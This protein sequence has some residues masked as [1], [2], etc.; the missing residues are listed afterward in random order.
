[1]SERERQEGQRERV[2][3]RERVPQGLLA[4]ATVLFLSVNNRIIFSE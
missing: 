1:V 3:E 2:S 4:L